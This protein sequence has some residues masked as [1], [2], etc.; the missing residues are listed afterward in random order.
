MGQ[1]H[2]NQSYCR[3]LREYYD[4]ILFS[5]YMQSSRRLKLSRSSELGKPIPCYILNIINES[6][7][8]NA[9]PMLKYYVADLDGNTW[10]LVLFS[11]NI[12]RYVF[13]D[14]K[15]RNIRLIFNWTNTN[16]SIELYCNFQLTKKNTQYLVPC[17]QKKQKI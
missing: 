15:N 8:D 1:C 14:P 13:V 6:Y 16:D 5:E 10:E 9:N 17:L 2:S 11:K 4:E 3:N 7:K 12:N